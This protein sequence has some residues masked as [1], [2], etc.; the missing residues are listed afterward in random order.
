VNGFS[1][2]DQDWLRIPGVELLACWA[3]ARRGFVDAIKLQPK[4]KAGRANEMVK[5][6]AEL[7]LRFPSFF[8][9]QG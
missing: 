5:M 3:H 1:G 7:Y 2:C 9:H 6:I 8:A 4:G